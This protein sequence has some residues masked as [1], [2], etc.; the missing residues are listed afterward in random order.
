MS[1]PKGSK[2]LQ[3]VNY[4]MRVTIQDGRQMVGK[5]LAFDR[6]MNLV[7]GDCEEF[8]RLPPSKSSKASG[9]REDRRTLGL[10]LLRGEEVVSMTVEGPP[11]PDESRAKAGGG[12][13]ALAGP[14]VG[15]AAGRG[16]PSGPL[17]QA[18]PGLAGPV[19]GVGGPAPGMMQPQISRS[20]MPNLSAP[21][22]AYPQVMRPP[23]PGQAP[24]AFPGQRPPPM[25][26]Q[27]Q[28]PT[29]APPAP[30]PGGP[31]PPSQYMRGPPPMG[32]PR[33]GMPGMPPPLRPGMP[34][35]PMFRPGMPPQSGPQ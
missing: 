26:M 23:L 18:Q 31:P 33:P 21:P 12:A 14:G 8:R 24:T 3:F 17:L 11:P 5:F 19:R 34:P 29:G 13:G 1:N 35:P 2:M 25:P 10:M 27:F 6:H 7:L 20:P 30:F 4:R 28:R 22:V 16:V 32:P 15:R 9:D